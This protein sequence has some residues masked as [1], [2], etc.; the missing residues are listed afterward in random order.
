MAGRTIATRNANEMRLAWQ[1]MA[2]NFGMGSLSVAVIALASLP[3]SILAG[4]VFGLA[5]RSSSGIFRY[6]LDLLR[7]EAERQARLARY[8]AL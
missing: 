4:I 2:L 8:R 7:S 1:H 5:Y 3:V 6:R